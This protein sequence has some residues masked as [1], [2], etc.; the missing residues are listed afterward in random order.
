MPT[1]LMRHPIWPIFAT[2]G[3]LCSLGMLSACS[4]STNVTGSPARLR[5][6]NATYIASSTPATSLATAWPVDILIDS[7]AAAPS[8]ANLTVNQV[9]TGT[10]TQI[11]S[12]DIAFASA[13][14]VDASIGPH[15]FVASY[16]TP[17]S[18]VVTNSLFTN[19]TTEP[20]LPRINLRPGAAYTLIVAGMGPAATTAQVPT[21][22]NASTFAFSLNTDDPFSPPSN[23]GTY[24]ARIR[25]Y[26]AAPFTVTTGKGSVVSFYLTTGTVHP[27]TDSLTTLQSTGS[28]SLGNASVYRNVTPG[29]Y[30]L[31]VLV[32]SVLIYQDS[33]AIGSGDVRS[34]FLLNDFSASNNQVPAPYSVGPQYFRIVSILD[35]QY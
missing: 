27:R 35:N 30:T 2:T 17:P 9:S 24:N 7:S 4:D 20:Y 34:F 18:G 3:V 26:N 8:Y 29:T 28:A 22:I 1:S 10:S 13:G 23:D 11:G 16:H 14:Y 15:S 33:V 19:S 25:F 6:V 31:S 21:P 5:F 12:N 32:G